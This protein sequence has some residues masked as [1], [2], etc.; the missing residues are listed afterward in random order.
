MHDSKKN[1]FGLTERDMQTI[2]SVF[3]AYPEI[4]IVHI[5]GSRAK[6]NYKLGSDI[7]LAI[8]NKGVDSIT[9]TRVLDEFEESN[10]PYR[11]DLVDYSKL[12]KQDFIDHI[13]RVG[14]PILNHGEMVLSF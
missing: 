2:K 9:L 5:F 14:I 10:L 6:G 11:V 7:D 13:E 8:M 4:K 1:K 3:E 12:T